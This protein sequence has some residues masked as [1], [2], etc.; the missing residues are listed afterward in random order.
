MQPMDLGYFVCLIMIPT[1][2]LQKPYQLKWVKTKK[3]KNK[4]YQQ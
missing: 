4:G 1:M 2:K 3:Q